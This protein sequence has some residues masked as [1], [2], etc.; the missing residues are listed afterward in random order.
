MKSRAL[1][2]MICITMFMSLFSC[3][4]ALQLTYQKPPMATAT[5]GQLYVEV[6]DARPPE[7]GGN[8]PYTVGVIR[9]AVGIPYDVKAAPD[10]EPSIVVKELISECLMSAGY[11][12]VNDSSAAP[13]L[14]A[15]LKKFWSDGY[16]HNRIA[17]EM[18]IVLQK[19]ENA[20]S[21][22]T[23]VLDVNEGFTPMGFGFSQ[24]NAGY[25][26]MLDVAKD[27]LIEQFTSPEFENLYRTLD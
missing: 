5:I 1:L 18:P 7:K 15:S 9:S 13:H 14:Q 24:F 17:L 20:A 19:S 4:N 27:K 11:R 23:Y 22:W 25:N 10:R 26:R 2:L 8:D 21:A 12:I 16:V 6:D 3:S